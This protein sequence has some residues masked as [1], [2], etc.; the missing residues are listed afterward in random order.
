MTTPTPI[1]DHITSDICEDSLITVPAT[2]PTYED[3]DGDTWWLTD[4][5]HDGDHVML[6]APCDTPLMLRRDA[7]R[8]HG[9]LVRAA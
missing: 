2:W 9:P 4:Y 8:L 6:P 5:T 1:P 7:E 3:R